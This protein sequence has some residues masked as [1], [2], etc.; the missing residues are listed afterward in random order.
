LDALYRKDVHKLSRNV[1]LQ[2]LDNILRTYEAEMIPRTATK[3]QAS[4]EAAKFLHTDVAIR[5]GN[6]TRGHANAL[7]K[8]DD[9]TVKPFNA[10][11]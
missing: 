9:V 11:F 3:V 7:A 10:I 2:L 5:E 6:I 1:D 8:G 4:A